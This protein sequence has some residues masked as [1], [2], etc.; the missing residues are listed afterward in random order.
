M[1]QRDSSGAEARA[2]ADAAE[3]E[4]NGMLWT[5]LILVPVTF[6]GILV[7]ILAVI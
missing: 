5:V 6:V 1:T 7:G 4:D 3:R 2:Q